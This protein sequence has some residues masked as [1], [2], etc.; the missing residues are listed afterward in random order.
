[1]HVV[2]PKC[3]IEY[4][5]SDD[6]SGKRVECEC[7]HKFTASAY[8]IIKVISAVDL[9]GADHYQSEIEKFQK[10]KDLSILAELEPA[11]LYD[12]NAIV[13]K[14]AATGGKIGYVSRYHAAAVA[15]LDGEVLKLSAALYDLSFTSG[16]IE[17]TIHYDG[18]NKKNRPTQD[19]ILEKYPALNGVCFGKNEPT[20]P[21]FAYA[22]KLG[23][24]VNKK[25]FDSISLAI[26]EAK[27]HEKKPPIKVSP[28][29]IDILY[30]KLVSLSPAEAGYMADIKEYHIKLDRKITN[31]QAEDVLAFIENHHINCPYCKK[32]LNSDMFSMDECIFCDGSFKTL[33]IPI[34]LDDVP[35]VSTVGSFLP[36]AREKKTITFN[37]GSFIPTK[38]PQTTQCLH[39]KKTI[40]A[41]A[42]ICPYCRNTT[43]KGCTAGCWVLVFVI[44]IMFFLIKGC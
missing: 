11:N 13:I 6:L 41:T 28:E 39:C 30:E 38:T 22:L 21:Q 44:V 14:N 9:A 29:D 34:C 37:D 16:S 43:V 27:E 12:S 4:D 15:A 20:V 32:E 3:F 40:D 8:N 17:L 36:A 2:C 1:M 18:I 35:A 5:L 42:S 25:T 19:N 33:K 31:K 10:Q 23:I 24:N 7:G 26:D